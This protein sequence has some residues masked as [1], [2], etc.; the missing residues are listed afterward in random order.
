MP[1]KKTNPDISRRTGNSIAKTNEEN[2]KEEKSTPAIKLSSLTKENIENNTAHTVYYERTQQAGR[3]ERTERTETSPVAEKS[4]SI[5][6][7]LWRKRCPA[8]FHTMIN[9]SNVTD[10]YCRDILVYEVFPRSKDVD[11]FNSFVNEELAG[12]EGNQRYKV[13]GEKTVS[14]VYRETWEGIDGNNEPRNLLYS[15]GE[16]NR[17]EDKKSEIKAL[18]EMIEK[19]DYIIKEV[20]KNTFFYVIKDA[21]DDILYYILPC[22][23]KCHTLLPNGW[24]D[25][26]KLQGYMPVMM[27]A[28]PTGGK[29]TYMSALLMAGNLEACLNTGENNGRWWSITT[30]IPFER[31]RFRIQGTR[32]KNL[33]RFTGKI[34]NEGEVDTLK[35]F[36]EHTNEHTILPP[37]YIAITDCKGTFGNTKLLIGIFD[38]AGETFESIENFDNS[39]TPLLEKI[40]GL[41][42]MVEPKN[43]RGLSKYFSEE[44]SE[45]REVSEKKSDG[46]FQRESFPDTKETGLQKNNISHSKSPM[47]YLLNILDILRSNAAFGSN[48]SIRHIAF[49]VVKSNQ[50]LDIAEKEHWKDDEEL[51][52]FPSYL[53]QPAG[54][55]DPFE[56]QGRA[57]RDETIKSFFRRVVINDQLEFQKVS[58]QYVYKNSISYSWNCVNVAIDTGVDEMS[59]EHNFVR[60]ADP[61]VNCFIS[62]VTDEHSNNQ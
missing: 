14:E 21:L 5:Q 27:V 45:K 3:T 28:P 34:R 6:M 8:K 37:V 50:L 46:T 52:L 38:V 2:N 16:G 54:G 42:Y 18:M 4:V 7:D 31:E 36:P 11:D 20:G 40:E 19:T 58:P 9:K 53:Q 59:C 13:I 24:F 26:E 47:L 60:I 25:K 56:L 57:D 32:Y 48:I 12:I 15:Q 29:T 17:I 41:I 51:M 43:M 39:I 10:I 30:G 61:F 1:L 62:K 49:T 22:C 35:R 44:D 23:P 55:L 33:D